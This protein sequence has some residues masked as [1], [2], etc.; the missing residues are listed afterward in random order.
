M[1]SP[2]ILIILTSHSE[3][4]G[5]GYKTGFYPPELAHA[6]NVLAP[7][8][9]IT[10]ASP[11][12][13]EAPIIEESFAMFQDDNETMIFVAEKGDVLRETVKLETLVD[14]A[15]EFSAVYFPGGH[16]REQPPTELAVRSKID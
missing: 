6:Y 16:G 4:K 8:V 9:S 13:G 10:I 2:K 12:G 15:K 7:H 11:A 5:T 1:T 14:Q 3:V